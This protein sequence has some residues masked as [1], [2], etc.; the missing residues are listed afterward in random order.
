MVWETTIESGYKRQGGR[1][2]IETKGQNIHSCKVQFITLV[3]FNNS[4]NNLFV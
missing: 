2:G 1:R 3:V 4:I